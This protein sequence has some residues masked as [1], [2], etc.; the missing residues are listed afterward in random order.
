MIYHSLGKTKHYVSFKE[1]VIRGLAPDNSLFFPEKIHKIEIKNFSSQSIY[2]IAMEV[3]KPY[4][5]PDIPEKILEEIIEDTLCFPFPLVNIHKEIYALELFHGPSIA[6]KDV[7]ARFMAGC[8]SYLRKEESKPITVLVAT[9]GDT[10]GAVAK[11]FHQIAGVEVVLIFPQSKISLFQEKQLSSVKDNITSLEIEG[12]FDD[13]QKL[14]KE[15]FLDKDLQNKC[16]LTSANSINIARLLPQ[17][18]YYFI[19]YKNISPSEAE[20]VFFSIPC[21]NFGNLCAGMLAKKM[22]L[23]IKHFIAAINSNDTVNRFIKTGKYAF[24][25]GKYTLS[26]AMDVADPSNFTRIWHLSDRSFSK[27]KEKLDTYSFTDEETICAIESI[28]HKNGYI[29][30]PHGALGYLGLQKYFQVNSQNSRV[31]GVF[32]E[33]AHPLKFTEKIPYDLQKQV[34]LPKHLKKLLKSEKKSIILP[35]NYPALKEHLLNRGM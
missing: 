24:L 14:V 8:L 30:D 15:A 27:L 21:G 31:L 3:I 4:I 32:L 6:F 25:P 20:E 13:C 34:I 1:A 12:T 35:N 22:G 10:G 19:V 26:N 33:T 18:L 17:I 5:V 23:P 29:L 16:A 9:S 7:G 2:S 11:G 28:F